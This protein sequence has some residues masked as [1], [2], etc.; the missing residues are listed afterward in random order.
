MTDELRIVVSRGATGWLAN[1]E[2]RGVFYAGASWQEAVRDLI[3][4]PRAELPADTSHSIPLES[5]VLSARD[6]EAG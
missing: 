1:I 4:A 5:F 2:G 6:G 3:D